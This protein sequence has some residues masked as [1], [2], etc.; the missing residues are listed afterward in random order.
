[1]TA[2]EIEMEENDS[3]D[4]D[5][6]SQLDFDSRMLLQYCQAQGQLLNTYSMLNKNNEETSEMAENDHLEEV[7]YSEIRFI[8][9]LRNACSTV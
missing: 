6:V 3:A 8:G 1:M 2:Q 7:N 4:V 9:C 5:S